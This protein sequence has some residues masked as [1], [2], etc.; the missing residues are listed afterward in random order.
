M[1]Q[2]SITAAAAF[3]GLALL[4][5]GLVTAQE[6]A[7]HHEMHRRHRDPKAYAAALEDPAR[8][9]YQKP[10]QVVKALDLR[11]GEAVAD[12]GSG[13]GYFTLRF[14]EAV[15]DS[16]TVYAV[17]VSPD[18]V[19][20]LNRRLRDRGVGNVVTVLADPTDPLLRDGSVDRFVIVDTWHHIEDQ[21]G[22]LEKMKRMLR[23]GGQVVHID[24]KK[25]DLPVGPPPGHK[26]AR[27]DVVARM[28]EAGFRLTAEHDFLPYQ[29]FLV[30]EPASP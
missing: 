30:F 5:S 21:G 29:Y 22:Y 10:D 23:P 25:G 6:A 2:L 17:D 13:T 20:H 8:D 19:R 12:I 26:I 11:E 14:A 7:G 4:W 3:A 1:R 9:E 27:G 18:M 15:G 24:F 28:E 16:G